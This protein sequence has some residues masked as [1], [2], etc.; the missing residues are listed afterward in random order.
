MKLLLASQSPRRNELLHLAGFEFEV[1]VPEVD[2][3]VAA[4]WKAEEVPEL[5]ARKKANA[6]F[7]QFHPGNETVVVAA[8]TIV[9]FQGKIFGKP[10]NEAEALSMLESLSGN[11][12]KVITGV[13][14]RTAE[15][16]ISFSDVSK[17]FF[18]N[19]L[20]EELNYYI[21]HFHPFDKA[22]SYGIQD[23]IGVRIVERVEGDY[24]N[25]MGLPVRLVA[26]A[27][28]NFG[29]TGMNKY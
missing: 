22:G 29:I 4:D 5:L 1:K 21:R 12:H 23:W 13:S 6:V 26:E 3:T 14:I 11:E 10:T 16:E 24:F 20:K 18:R 27:L 7:E 28:K 19:L 25:V 15:K 9:I 8:D 2:E 17:V